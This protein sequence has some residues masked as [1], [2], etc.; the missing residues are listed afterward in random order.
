MC[1][2]DYFFVLTRLLCHW[3][4]GMHYT[5]T[6]SPGTCIR[7]LG[8]NVVSADVKQLFNPVWCLLSDGSDDMNYGENKHTDSSKVLFVITNGSLSFADIHS[9]S[10]NSSASSTH[11]GH[12]P[13]IVWHPIHFLILVGHCGTSK[14]S[15]GSRSKLEAFHPI[16]T[17]SGRQSLITLHCGGE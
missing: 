9:H 12:Q 15:M 11:A 14:C 16:I 13:G 3:I 4:L 6:I 5:G 2:V 8:V 1:L 10:H 7:Q 17:K